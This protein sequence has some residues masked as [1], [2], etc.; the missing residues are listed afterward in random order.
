MPHYVKGKG[1]VVQSAKHVKIVNDINKGNMR[2]S[3]IVSVSF[4]GMFVSATIKS[5]TF[6]VA[7]N[8]KHV[9]FLII[10]FY[11]SLTRTSMCI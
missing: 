10:F 5:V 4:P 8:I 7:T 11:L 2:M 1:E 9:V 6:S 3:L